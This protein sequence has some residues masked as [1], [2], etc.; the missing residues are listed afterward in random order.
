MNNPRVPRCV[1]CG[2]IPV[3]TAGSTC[4]ACM[5]RTRVARERGK[6]LAAVTIPDPNPTVPPKGSSRR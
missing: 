6:R 4:G 3:W 1:A 5:T 2:R